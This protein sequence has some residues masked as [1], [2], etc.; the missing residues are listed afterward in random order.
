M[1]SKSRK[2]SQKR[3]KPTLAYVGDHGTGTDAAI[4]GTYLEPITHD[5]KP[6]PNRRARRRRVEVIETLSFLSMRQ[7][8]A[9]QEI[10]NAYCRKEM[11]SSGGPLK[12]QVDTSPRP[13]VFAA[14]QVD[15]ETRWRRC[16]DPV[17]RHM[18]KTV[19]AVCCANTP[20]RQLPVRY[21]VAKSDLQ[22]ALTLVANALRY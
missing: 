9:A 11:M 4:A 3:K 13:D 18:R 6:D 1:S 19:E 10:R 14:S 12:E 21:E 7:L 16:I 17:P 20:L 5:G 2:R 8:Q 22:G 15:A